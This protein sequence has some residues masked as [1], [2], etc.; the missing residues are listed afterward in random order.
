MARKHMDRTDS[1]ELAQPAAA[2]QP[3]RSRHR[4]PGLFAALGLAAAAA[5]WGW[6][7]GGAPETLPTPASTAVAQA[8]IATAQVQPAAARGAALV[9]PLQAESTPAPTPAVGPDQ[10][11]LTLIPQAGSVGW[12]RS[13]DSRNNH[14]GD[15]YIYSGIS[16]GEIFHGAIQFDLSTV[17]RGA[18][19]S[20]AALTLT[21]LDDAR[22]DRAS[23]GAWQARWLDPAL[24]AN[25]GRLSFQEIHN[26]PVVQTILPALGETDLALNARNV[27]LFDE[28]QIA[29][30]QQALVEEQAQ[31][32]FRLDGPE[33]GAENLFAW[34]T[35]YGPQSAGSRPQLLLVVG[36]APA[37][38]PAVPASDLI[39]VTSTP[40][41]QNVLTAAASQVAAT[42]AASQQGTATPTPLNMV[43]ATSTPENQTTAVAMGGIWV[44]TPTPTPANPATIRAQAAYATAQAMTTGTWTPTP[45]YFV[46]ATATPTFVIITNTPTP[47]SASALLAWAVA[48][49][50][51]VSQDGPPT[52]IPPGFITATPRFIIATGTPTPANGATA[53][54]IRVL[55]TVAALTTG[56][57][58]PMPAVITPTPAATAPATA[59]PLVAALTRTPTLTPAPD[60][61]PSE[62]RGKILFRSDRL[63]SDED[64]FVLDPA[65]LVR[66]GGCTDADVSLLTNP[67]PHVLASAAEPRAPD[68]FRTAVVR[69][70]NLAGGEGAQVARV[71]I[72]DSRYNGF[73]RLSP[74]DGASYDPVWS[75]MDDRIALVSTD[76]GN[77]EIFVINADGSELRQLTN[78][79][80]EW[81]K[82]PTWS[83]DGR[84]I[85]F[86]SNRDTGRRQLWM[87][88]A[89]GSEQRIV[90]NSQFND[91]DPIWIK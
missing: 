60:V 71:F 14:F 63:G 83:P 53:Q 34:D 41:P 24:N 27:F 40:T 31:I 32:V 66:T 7:M 39:V 81:D 88:K 55:A 22:L 18:P 58:T 23:N 70:E 42:A 86:Y 51:R 77:D 48:E 13:N 10:Q 49:A 43:T 69:M 12:A 44:V 20:Y 21:G 35:G 62:L 87:M 65:C 38:P 76:S 61:I 50:T 4:W 33:A 64:L 6:S 19:I 57:Y 5:L 82:H 29:A 9:P 80:W 16:Q 47:N 26:A 25:W 28:Q 52:A 54:A 89:D 85:L 46:A 11:L 45:S 30:L 72:Q 84:N 68:G 2:R 8:P 75:P 78:N 74:F 15:S 67:Y 79:S 56:T 59:L 37:T 36:P 91:W 90:T 73:Q 3:S 1:P 17:A